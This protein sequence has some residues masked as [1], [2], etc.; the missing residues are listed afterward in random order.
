MF[1]N[2]LD[3]AVKFTPARGSIHISVIE[4][5]KNEINLSVCDTGVGIPK[6]KIERIF[7]RFYQVDQSRPGTEAGSGLGL[8][9]CKKIVEAHG[10][11]IM[12]EQNKNKGICFTVCLPA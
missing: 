11:K 8:H 4:T 2:L 3:N 10:G 9:I 5:K 12:A 1:N 7:D 6:D